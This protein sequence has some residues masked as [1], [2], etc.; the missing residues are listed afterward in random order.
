MNVII[1]GT[2]YLPPD[3]SEVAG[4]MKKHVENLN[5]GAGN[6]HVLEWASDLHVEFESIHPFTDGNGRIGRLLLSVLTLKNGY[7][8]VVI[9]PIRRAEYIAAMQ[10]ANKG[11]MTAL[12]A[13]VLSVISL[14][15]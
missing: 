15:R 11:D 3:Y 12:R 14:V 10:K 7:C 6:K 13:L 1:T 5:S 2:D 9:P 4:L 8:P